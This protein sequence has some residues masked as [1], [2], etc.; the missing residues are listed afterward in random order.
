MNITF[1]QLRLFL[2]LEQT[3]SVTKASRMMHISQP[4]AS[5]QLKDMTEKRIKASQ[6]ILNY[7]EENKAIDDS[8]KHSFELINNDD[9]FNN[10]NTTY[11]YEKSMGIISATKGTAT[12]VIK[13]NIYSFLVKL[14][15]DLAFCPALV[16][17]SAKN[18]I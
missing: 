14:I 8:L 4:T 18:K 16:K 7:F 12:N 13:S 1:K 17:K 5:M 6:T 15:I 9:L 2:A 10:A 3:E 11:K